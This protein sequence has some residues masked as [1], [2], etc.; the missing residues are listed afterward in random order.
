MDDDAKMLL[1]IIEK[2][3]G[4]IEYTD[5]SSPEVIKENTGLSKNA[6]K[7]AIGRL[8]KERKITINPDG[9]ELA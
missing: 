6:F 7:R 5:K 4:K 8:Y 1:D 2:A 3:G 9:I